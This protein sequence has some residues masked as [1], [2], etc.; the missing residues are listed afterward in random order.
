MDCSRC[1]SNKRNENGNRKRPREKV[2]VRDAFEKANGLALVRTFKV[3]KII[4]LL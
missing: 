1:L 2:W 4:Y 3:F